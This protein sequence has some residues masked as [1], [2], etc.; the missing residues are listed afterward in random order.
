MCASTFT[1]KCSCTHC[2]RLR[3]GGSKPVSSGCTAAL[4]AL[5]E[6]KPP[7]NWWKTTDGFYSW[8]SVIAE[9]TYRIDWTENKKMSTVVSPSFLPPQ[10]YLHFTKEYLHAY[11]STVR[12]RVP[13][14]VRFF[15]NFIVVFIYLGAQWSKIINIIKELFFPHQSSHAQ[16]WHACV[17]ACFSVSD[18]LQPYYL[19]PPGSSVHGI[20]QA[21]LL[22]W[23]ALF[24][25][26]GS[27]QPRDLNHVSDVSCIGRRVLNHQRH[28]LNKRMK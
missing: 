14:K 7:R 6:T 2:W 24:S 12:K 11:Y 26:R 27:S 21:R 25:S 9:Y 20:L 10:T 8:T 3:W 17:L 15:T 4:L 13:P 5:T 18:S 28:H 16:Q 1:Y 23:V 19:S 22:D